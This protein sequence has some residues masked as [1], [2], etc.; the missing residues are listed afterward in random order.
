MT[1]PLQVTILATLVDRVGQPPQERWKLFSEYYS[2]IYQREL[3]REIEAA[4]VLRDHQPDIDAIHHR[5]AM[6]LQVE[7]ESAQH[8]DAKMSEKRFASIV[9]D[10]LLE[11]GHEGDN[12]DKLSSEI[13]RA[14][15]DRL[16]FLVG[17]ESDA[18]GFEVRSLQ[19]FMAA[20][21]LMDGSDVHVT[22][23]LRAIAGISS[24]RNV[25][26]FAAGKCFAEKQHLR[27]TINT[28]CAE[29]ND[30]QTDPL[31][32]IVFPGSVLAANLLEDGFARKQPN[33]ARLL[34][35]EALKLLKRPGSELR[36]AS[37]FQEPL[38]RL[39]MDELDEL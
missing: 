38:E 17:L 35:S 23:R 15:A 22:E 12:L 2:V 18:L 16:V 9:R 11:E 14:A 3:E 8:A 6:V 33:Y 36:L 20:E 4:T 30:P 29:L 25:Y 26:L 27:D 1:S 21:A 37:A 13:I 19:E 5:V 34:G 7:S 39:Y 10:R 31:A 28:I 24:W 32:P